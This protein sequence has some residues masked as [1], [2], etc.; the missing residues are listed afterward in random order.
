[1]SNLTWTDFEA[2]W[3]ESLSRKF[4]WNF[5]VFLKTTSKL[6]W[7]FLMSS[8]DVLRKFPVNYLRKFGSFR[9]SLQKLQGSLIVF[10][11][12]KPSVWH[13]FVQNFLKKG[14]KLPSNCL[15]TTFKVLQMTW[16]SF[17][18]VSQK[19]TKNWGSF[20]L[21]KSRLKKKKTKWNL[22]KLKK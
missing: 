4:P 16:S 14:L 7:N 3:H 2:L 11:C 6:P 19:T 13:M 17:E 8:E 18:E 12:W 10:D 22:S 21:S 15:Q 5:L 9:C 1:M 20:N